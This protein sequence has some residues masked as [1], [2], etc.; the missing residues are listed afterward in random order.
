MKSP[1]ILFI[2]HDASRTGAPIIFLNFLRWFKQNTDIPF[3]I[4]LR[5]GGPLESEFAKIAPVSIFYKEKP[6]K[7][8]LV[9]RIFNRLGFQS[10]KRNAYIN[11]IKDKL[12]QDNIGLIYTNTVVN[13]DVLEFLADL[14]CPV[15]C[16]VHELEIIIQKY[17]E[18]FAQVK[19]HTLSYI[20]V[21]KAVKRNLIENHS[22]PEEKIKLVYGFIPTATHNVKSD[23]QEQKLIFEQLGISPEA[24]IVCSS[25]TTDW[26]KGTDLFIQLALSVSKR[27]VDPV[28]FLWIGGQTKGLQFERLCYDAKN[29]GLEKYVHFLGVQ[30]N[31]LDY[32]AT[33]DVFALVSREDPFPLVCLEAASLG[34]PIVCFDNAGGEKEFVEDDCG[35][36]VPYLDIQT[37]ADK[38]IHLLENRDL[39][40]QM[41]SRA[42]Q[43]VRE[44]HNE[45]LIGQQITRVIEKVTNNSNNLRSQ[46]EK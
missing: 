29:I 36:V 3:K 7:R 45:K 43:K 42:M 28:H 39:R 37:M 46:R 44:K 16:H 34:K 10:H 2:S 40:E 6:A 32:F 27:Y 31:P 33:C 11:S 4:L 23:R 30:P 12:I 15:I 17:T 20:A 14:K 13:G 19:K 22:I 5:K 1:Q 9:T 41:G 8:N 21:S 24:K 18:S 26:R 25:G 38:V 35:F